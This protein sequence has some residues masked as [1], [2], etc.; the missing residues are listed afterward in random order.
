MLF[1]LNMFLSLCCYTKLIC[2]SIIAFNNGRT[3]PLQPEEVRHTRC[4]GNSRSQRDPGSTPAKLRTGDRLP[5]LRE[6]GSHQRET[7]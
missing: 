1:G 2:F 3:E 5:N 4:G 6:T 7:R